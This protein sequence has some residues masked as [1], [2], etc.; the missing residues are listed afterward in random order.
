MR[1]FRG[2]LSRGILVATLLS[3]TLSGCASTQVGN[4][5]KDPTYEAKTFQNVLVIAMRTD[6]TR[7][8][9]WEDNFALG[10][11]PYGTKVQMS[12]RLWPTSLPDTAAVVEAVRRDGFDG[13]L[14]SVREDVKTEEWVPGY[15][16]RE[17]VTTQSWSGAY[18]TYWT[19]V[20]IP[21]RMEATTVSNF[22]TDLWQTTPPGHMVWSG[23]VQTTD[24]VTDNV[25]RDLVTKTILAE[26]EKANVLVKPA[27]K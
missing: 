18:Y 14:V 26:M 12:Y 13:V 3:A 21:D 6:Q 10:L 16:K 7:R 17:A 8:R 9:I 22:R 11:A 15:T 23:T 19:D 1:V 2:P 25:V 5:W 24:A 4:M 20:E 27:K